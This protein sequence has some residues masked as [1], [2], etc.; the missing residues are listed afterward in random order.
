M[1]TDLLLSVLIEFF[2]LAA[3]TPPAAISQQTI[4]AWDSL[5]MVQLI[6]ELQGRFSVEFSLDEIGALRSY[7]EIRLALEKKDKLPA[8]QA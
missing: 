6:T 4:A 5:A 7:D 1:Q 3:I 2:D 8:V